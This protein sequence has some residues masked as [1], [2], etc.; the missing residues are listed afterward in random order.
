MTDEIN[1]M[2]A[3]TREQIDAESM[4]VEVFF[5]FEHLPPYLRVVSEPFAGLACHL[6]ATLSCADE[7]RWALRK[8]LEAKDAAVR[9]AVLDMRAAKK[10]A[11]EALATESVKVAQEKAAQEKAAAEAEWRAAHPE[12]E[13]NKN[14]DPEPMLPDNS[15][16]VRDHQREIR[17]LSDPDRD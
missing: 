11:D 9:Q 15:Q 5:N 13:D 4:P 6:L 3:P 8:L 2:K 16:A 17:R 14:T 10:A 7:R 1:M 12:A